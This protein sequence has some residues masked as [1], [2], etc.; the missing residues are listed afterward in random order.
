ML[1]N[2]TNG[3][4][5]GAKGEK[6]QKCTPEE[7]QAWKIA[8]A[9]ATIVKH[10]RKKA[11]KTHI[12]RLTAQEKEEA[13]VLKEANKQGKQKQWG[14]NMLLHKKSRKAE[15]TGI[16]QEA[17]QAV[18]H[19]NWLQW[20]MDYWQ[21]LLI[22]LNHLFLTSKKLVLLISCPP[23]GFQYGTFCFSQS[24]PPP[25]PTQGECCWH[26]NI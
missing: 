21:W 3:I 26:I 17:K 24:L 7:R 22:T 23:D 11:R 4:L 2:N 25:S 6:Y 16:T 13:R 12:K 8:A 19:R 20:R 15:A 14:L 10:A 1:C 18:A 5:K 9:E